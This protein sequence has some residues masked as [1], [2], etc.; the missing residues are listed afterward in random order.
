MAV[1]AS[2]SLALFYNFAFFRNL[3]VVYPATWGRLPFLGSI[4]L[5]LTCFTSLL[6]IAVGSK[7]T[8]K[9]VLILV[10]AASS[11]ASYF[12]NTFNVVIDAEMFRNVSQTNAA[13]TMDLMNFKLLSYFLL[14]GVV[15]SV[16]IYRARV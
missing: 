10:L 11:V 12:M 3:L 6:F 15:P 9:P 8:L 16:L 4:F 5:V 14:L 2:I 7:Y 13:E 1:L